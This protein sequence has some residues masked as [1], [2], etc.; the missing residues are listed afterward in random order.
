MFCLFQDC[1]S[2]KFIDI[3]IY[4]THKKP[5]KSFKTEKNIK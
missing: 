1:F 4:Q 3:A 5:N 2:N